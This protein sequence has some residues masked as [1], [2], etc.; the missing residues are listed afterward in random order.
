MPI[1]PPEPD[2]YP[3]QLL[4]A[5]ETLDIPDAQWWALY[6]MSRREKELMRRLRGM[7]VPFYG[8]LAP[9]R[10]RTANGRKRVSYNPLFPG[11]VFLFGDAE[12]RRLALTTNCISRVLPIPDGDDLVRDLR[13]V[14]QLILADAPLTPESRLT[15]GM[16][17]RVRGG[18]LGGLEGVVMKRRGKGRLLVAVEFLQQGASVALEDCEVEVL[19]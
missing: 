11:Y 8:P 16:R 3:E 15:P 13:Q 12:H 5:T 6:T 17:V 1:L 14:R 7:K 4:E 2:L 19:A 10:T 18:A 9:R